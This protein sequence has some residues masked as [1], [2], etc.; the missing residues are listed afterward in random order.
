MNS[1]SKKPLISIVTVVFNDKDWL[2]RTIESVVSQTYRDIEFIIID[3]DSNDGTLDVISHYKNRI[4]YWVSEPDKGMYDAL[5]K[6][7]SVATGDFI[8]FL[9]AGDTIKDRNSL[10]N[11]VLLMHDTAA[12]YYSRAI[13][14]TDI[15]VWRYPAYSVHNAKAWVKNNLPNCQSM[16]FPKEIYKKY[17][18]DLRLCLTSDDDYK[19]VAMNNS[20]LR[21]MDV[22]FVE[23]RRDGISSNHKSLALFLQRVKESIIINLKH[24]RYIRLFLDPLKRLTTFAVHSFF[25]DKA[26]LKFIKKIKKL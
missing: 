5:N 21:F 2:I 9:M 19:I 6:G 23:F 22:E 24:K 16:F 25:G 13:I 15:G 7:I 12:T 10:E 14:I 20:R 8:N 18:F 26:F 1:L 3:G 4:A 17:N 11:A